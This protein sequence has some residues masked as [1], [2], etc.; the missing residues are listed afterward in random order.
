MINFI[1][2]KIQRL[3]VSKNTMKI[4]YLYHFFKGGYKSKK[5]DIS[6]ENK[7]SRVEI[8]NNIIKIK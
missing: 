4:F 1:K 8:V 2:K 3:L 5:I 7:K 6:F